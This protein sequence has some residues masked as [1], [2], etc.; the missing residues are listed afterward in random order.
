MNDKI[1]TVHELK[2]KINKF[3]CERGW[4]EGENT[5]NLV[6]ALSIEVAELMEI[7]QWVHSDNADSIKDE[8]E[9]FEHLREEIADVFWYLTRICNHY[10]IDL[11]KAVED[12]AVKNAKKYPAK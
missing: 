7:F 12:K 11:A 1:T 4:I 10:D 9:Q 3:S 5:K 6:M 8:P 2:D